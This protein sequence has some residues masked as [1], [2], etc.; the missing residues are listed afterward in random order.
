MCWTQFR[1]DVDGDVGVGVGVCF[2]EEN[3]ER[4]G[5]ICTE[6]HHGRDALQRLSHD[7]DRLVW[8]GTAPET[9][10]VNNAALPVGRHGAIVRAAWADEWNLEPRAATKPQV[11]PPFFDVTRK[12]IGTSWQRCSCNWT[13]L[14][15]PQL[16]RTSARDVLSA[17]V[18]LLARQAFDGN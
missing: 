10:N 16:L 5:S 12:R 6:L 11:T 3:D 13:P 17:C 2:A 14:T 18:Q 1:R 4:P 9:Q 8:T 15:I 7:E